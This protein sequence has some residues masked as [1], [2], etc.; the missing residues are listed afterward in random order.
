W[1]MTLEVCVGVV[2]QIHLRDTRRTFCPEGHWLTSHMSLPVGKNQPFMIKNNRRQRRLFV[3]QR[4]LTRDEL[5]TE[6]PPLSITEQRRA[7]ILQELPLVFPFEVRTQVFSTLVVQDRSQSQLRS[8]FNEGPMI[9]VAIRRTHIYEDAFEKLSYSNEPNLRLRMRVR[10][11]NAV[12]LDEAGIDGGGIFREF[13]SELLKTAL[14]PT[15]GFFLMTRD[16]TLYPNSGSHLIA[17]DYQTHYY[18][19]G[20][21]LGKALYENLLVEVPLAGFF[22]SKLLGRSSSSVEFHH[23]DSLDPELCRNLLYLKTYTGDVQD[24]GLD[25][26]ILTSDLGQ[27][28]VDE[29]IE[30]GSNITVNN[31]NRIEY[32]YRMA[33]YKL[34]RQIAKQCQAMRKGLF[35]VVPSEWLQMFDW[36]ELQMLISGSS[37]PIDLA[38]LMENTRY[39]GSYNTEHPTIQAYWRVVQEFSEL[40]MRQ[41]LKF[42]TSCSRPPLLGFRHILGRISVQP[43]GHESQIFAQYNCANRQNNCTNRQSNCTN[44]VYTII[45]ASTLE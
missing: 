8:D 24:L 28:T 5:E 17:E 21:M 9:N 35:D 30:D 39:G 3:P 14:D 25:F 4:L 13:L 33:D 27:N 15:R 42:V 26:T 32:I 20:R 16:N 19:I 12:G 43:S 31:E 10:L 44:P 41:L 2:R 34:N 29:L 18:F 11:M 45:L 37:T 36:K 6:G 7:T 1:S 38:D 22:L 40:Q 23:L